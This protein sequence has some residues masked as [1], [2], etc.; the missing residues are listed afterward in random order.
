ME[1]LLKT[2]I[3]PAAVF[4][5][6]GIVL[7]VLKI[8]MRRLTQRPPDFLVPRAPG[9]STREKADDLLERL[10][11]SLLSYAIWPVASSVIGHGLAKALYG[12]SESIS[13]AV[14]TILA[15]L[16]VALPLALRLFK[17]LLEYRNYKLGYK[18]E[19]VVASHLEE[20][21]SMGYH[22][23]HDMPAK[24]N[25]AAF[26]ID[27]VVVGP[28]GVFAIETKTRRKGGA[29][30][31]LNDHEVFYDGRRLI[32]PLWDESD[33]LDQAKRQSQ[34]LRGW[35]REQTTIDTPVAPILTIPG[36]FVTE[37]ANNGIRVVSPKILPQAIDG[38]SKTAQP[39]ESREIKYI[40]R[41]LKLACQIDLNEPGSN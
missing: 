22:V 37:K 23:F 4:G 29:R 28:K 10:T 17:R 30:P 19:L 26:N 8:E 31:G 15:F 41:Q 27:H 35:I 3:A 1:S 18:G 13:V 39:L 14:V 40:A 32:W 9:H 24:A 16:A 12:P 20:L 33:S 5:F 11:F 36:W 2:L 6:F 25:G 7:A 21:K 38:R 34:W